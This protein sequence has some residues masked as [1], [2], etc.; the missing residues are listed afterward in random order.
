MKVSFW[1][2]HCERAFFVNLP[3]NAKKDE[4]GHWEDTPHE[5]AYPGC[6]G[7]VGDIWEWEKVRVQSLL[8]PE[9]PVW[10]QRYPLYP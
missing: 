5:C 1:C 10:G 3:N 2:L 4:Y 9:T 8:Y 7:H 6:D